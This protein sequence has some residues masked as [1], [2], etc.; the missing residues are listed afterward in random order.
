MIEQNES[1]LGE[2]GEC[3]DNKCPDERLHYTVLFV[4]E[5]QEYCYGDGTNTIAKDW[6]HPLAFHAEF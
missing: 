1:D 3:S 2:R 6:V 5:E 4:N